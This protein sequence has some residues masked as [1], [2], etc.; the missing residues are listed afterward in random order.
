MFMISDIEHVLKIIMNFCKLVHI[1]D[2]GIR[3]NMFFLYIF[4]DGIITK[5]L[6]GEI[7]LDFHMMK[8]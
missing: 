6:T 3:V 1:K 8:T 2:C 7:E 5:P 4:H